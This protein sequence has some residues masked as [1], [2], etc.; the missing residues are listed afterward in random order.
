MSS[1][2]RGELTFRVRVQLLVDTD[3][4]NYVWFKRGN[5]SMKEI[6]LGFQIPSDYRLVEIVGL[7]QELKSEK[8]PDYEWLD[9]IRT[10]K[11]TNEARQSAVR[12]ALRSAAVSLAHKVSKLQCNLICGFVRITQNLLLC[13]SNLLANKT[14][15]RY[16]EYLD[17]EGS[18]TDLFTVRVLGTALRI[19]QGKYAGV[20]NDRVSFPILSLDEIPGNRQTG[21]GA[22]VAVRAV[23]ILERDDE[24]PDT[25]RKSWWNELRS[26]LH[27]QAVAIGCNMPELVYHANCIC[28]VSLCSI[29]GVALLGCSGT[30]V[31]MGKEEEATLVVSKPRNDLEQNEKTRESRDK[32][33]DSSARQP[34]LCSRF[35]TPPQAEKT[36][37]NAT[38]QI[39]SICKSG[40][41][42][43]FLI[44]S[45]SCPPVHYLIG[46]KLFIQV[47]VTKKI[48][49]DPDESEDYATE[50]SNVLPFAD[51]DL[52]NNL[53][54]EAK[55]LNPNANAVF[56]VHCTY[57]LSDS[58]LVSVVT[59][60]L[61][62]LA[63]LPRDV[64][65]SPSL[66]NVLSFT[67]LQRY[68]DAR[69]F[70]WGTVREAIRFK[71]SVTPG[72]SLKILNLKPPN[73]DLDETAASKGR[74]R[75]NNFVEKIRRRQYEKEYV[76][77]VVFER[78]LS[79]S[80]GLLDST[81]ASNSN[82][83]SYNSPFNKVAFVVF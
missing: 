35:H 69:R 1:G 53:L 3:W 73:S 44:S 50:V 28:W 48:S 24:D 38:T 46:P 19:E 18:S 57:S 22:V 34:I 16:Q 11:A 60:V 64:A 79:A 9:R 66:S 71:P 21:I 41:V 10:P 58:M 31:V 5:K 23:H 61:V 54:G 30:A 67:N 83:V 82:S 45:T 4:R 65:V 59:G 33:T 49:T 72:I 13:L 56:D 70:S 75:L 32:R 77:H 7:M 80:I 36:P 15:C 39:C 37:F 55:S 78:H 14:N 42:T 76:S 6:S 17:V 40:S 12:D 29:E 68:N 20:W 2:N 81:A 74:L 8:D 27:Q 43:D 51:H 63:C 26:E 47:S 62:R 25:T 52:F